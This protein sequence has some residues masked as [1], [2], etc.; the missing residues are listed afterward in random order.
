M[1]L[2]FEQ[3]YLIV[4]LI[5]ATIDLVYLINRKKRGKLTDTFKD[6]EEMFFSIN[7]LLPIFFVVNVF[8]YPIGILY[9]IYK[10]YFKKDL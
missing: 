7:Y 4:G 9:E 1:G 5:I 10:M 6:F 3:T 2:T 8:L